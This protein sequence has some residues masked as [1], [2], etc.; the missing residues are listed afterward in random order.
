MEWLTVLSKVL[1]VPRT[2]LWAL[3]DFS[4]E[5]IAEMKEDPEYELTVRSMILA[6]EGQRDAYAGAG[7]GDWRTQTTPQGEEKDGVLDVAEA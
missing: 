1:R 5:E 4:P 6:L 2:K 7:G 3:A